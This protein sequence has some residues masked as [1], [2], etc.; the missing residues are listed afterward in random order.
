MPHLLLVWEMTRLFS[1]GF[2]LLERLMKLGMNIARRFYL[3]GWRRLQG[4][5]ALQLIVEVPPGKLPKILAPLNT[6][7][8]IPLL[9]LC[10]LPTC[11]RMRPSGPMAMEVYHCLADLIPLHGLMLLEAGHCLT[12]FINMQSTL[13]F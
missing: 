1:K 4:A 12:Q 3:L 11:L 7:Q 5:V 9:E 8:L 2:R 13:P 6:L 10:L